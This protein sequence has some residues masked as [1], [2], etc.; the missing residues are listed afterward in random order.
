MPFVL[1]VRD[2]WPD[3]LVVKG[4]ITPLQARPLHWLV[5]SLYRKSDRIVSLTPGIKTE[6]VRKGVA[7]RKIDVFPNGF[8]PALFDV[9]GGTRERIRARYGWGNDFVAVY[10][11]SFQKVTA[12]EVFVRAAA[13]LVEQSGIRVALF[14][15]GPTWQ[16]VA[17]LVERLGLRNVE[18][19]APVPKREVPAVLAAAD[20][21]LMALFRSPLVHIYFENKLMDY[22][23]AGLPIVAAMEGEQARLLSECGAGQV[24]GSFDDEGLARL[25]LE[26][27]NAPGSRRTMGENGRRVVRERYLLPEIL[28]RYAE[29]VEA[30]AVGR[31]G[32]LEAWEPR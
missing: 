6:M 27:R 13:R 9:P 10:T 24:T 1:E 17:K 31:A 19:H 21:G 2:L 11:G 8:D 29:T 20:V 3:A 23:G 7:S 12:V 28:R 26:A 25:V 4:A 5:N 30:C 16:E 14:G 22:M 18:L 32:E 15:A